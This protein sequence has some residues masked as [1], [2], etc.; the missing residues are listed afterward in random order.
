[1]TDG[2]NASSDFDPARHPADRSA[3]KLDFASGGWVILLA[4]VLGVG[5][6]AW[7]L[8]LTQPY[9]GGVAIGDGHDVASYG[10]DL[11]NLAVP[12]EQLVAAGFPKDGLPVLV[13]PPTIA[14]AALDPKQRLGGVQK[15]VPHDRVVGVAINGE[16]RAYPLWILACHEVCND[17]LG[18]V[19][20]LVTYNP[21]CDSVV[22]FDR[23]VA[24]ET[25]TFGIS[26]LLYNSNLV[27]YDRRDT[28]DTES[29]WP[30]LAFR[31][32]AGPAADRDAQLTL[33]PAALTDWETWHAAHPETSI[34]LPDPNRYR[35]YRRDSYSVYFSTDKLRFP[36]APL[37]EDDGHPLKTP[38]CATRGVDGTWRVELYP[39]ATIVLGN[40][41]TWPLDNSA[42]I[43]AYAFRFAWHAFHP[44]TPTRDATDDLAAP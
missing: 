41:A 24:N 7:R 13:D 22:V 27:L 42:A 12:S 14:A 33:L 26:G 30:Q 10:F 1:M 38:V 23:R 40:G 2:R 32:I 31:A 35:L 18:G 39:D 5:I 8:V 37:P 16:A 9:R 17:D 4:I 20:I 11:S 15:L 36:V 34:I 21:L 25:L 28:P 3:R 6:V 43:R 19:P 29:L 44:E